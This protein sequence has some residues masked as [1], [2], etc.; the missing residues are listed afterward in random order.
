MPT[1]SRPPVSMSPVA[2]DLASS[3]GS[4]S[5]GTTTVVI[6]GTRSVHAASAPSRVSASGLLKA[7]RSPQHS[8]ENG[9][10]STV[11]AQRFSTPASR[12][13]SITGMVMP[14]CTSAIV[15]LPSTPVPALAA[16][17]L[18]R[19]YRPRPAALGGE[20]QVAAHAAARGAHGTSSQVHSRPA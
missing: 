20:Q 15:A 1:V 16:G 8:E 13:G 11:R 18:R 17:S 19:P 10:S 4:C 6:S 5:W 3:T 9:P 12:S 14:I 7:M 2:S